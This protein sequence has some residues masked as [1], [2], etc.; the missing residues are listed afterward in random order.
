MIYLRNKIK[1]IISVFL[2]MFFLS[3]F[4]QRNQYYDQTLE[5]TIQ[6][7]KI[8]GSNSPSEG[9]S[10]LDRIIKYSQ[11]KK[12]PYY[13]MIA[14]SNKV[15]FY[16][17]L[18]DFQKMITSADLTILQARKLS[19]YKKEIEA[20]TKKAW[21][22]VHL[23]LINEAEKQLTD[24]DPLLSKLDTNN[25]VD[26]NILGLYWNTYHEFYN[27]QEKDKEA[28]SKGLKSLE[29]FS[30]IKN[31]NNRTHRLIQAYTSIGSNYLFQSKA[32]S[33]LYYFTIGKNLFDFNS[34]PDKKSLAIIYSGSG[35][36]Y[37]IK[38]NYK[39]AIPALI[40]G[41]NV[42]KGKYPDIYNTSF[43]QL[44]EA[45]DNSTREDKEK[46]RTQYEKIK[47]D[48]AINNKLKSVEME[49]IQK[50]TD[51]NKVSKYIILWIIFV[52]LILSGA[53]YLYYKVRAKEVVYE[54]VETD[55]TSIDSREFNE[56]IDL[57]KKN[58]PAFVKKFEYAFP[59]FYQKLTENHPD[60]THTHIKILIYTYFSYTTKDIA[61]FTN[62]SVR[63]VQTHK[64]RIRKIINID[65]E[66]DLVGW[67]SK[68]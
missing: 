4:G 6:K 68:L 13:E 57:A 3:S 36:A 11:E 51:K 25:D 14:N 2:V 18:N 65:P 20:A 62:T 1:K 32:D 43:A 38:K 50:A 17:D 15:F 10:Q 39:A 31:R 59:D 48:I 26:L 63:T 8:L 16:S 66:E 5:N 7:A 61:T 47:S 28:V 23:G 42:S 40:E 54:K 24:I 30:K 22:Q 46:Y 60:L 64:Y 41:I 34:F 55:N 45:F 19:I 33:A 44:S 21:A 37:S 27:V 56:I 67:I 49:N 58:D 35:M 12:N 52:V 29:Y 53:V 9:I